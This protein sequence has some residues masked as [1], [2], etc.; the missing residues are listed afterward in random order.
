MDYQEIYKSWQNQKQ[1]DE[2]VRQDLNSIANQDD[3]IE[4]AFYTDLS[5]GTAGMRG[6]LGAG[7]NRMNR[8]TVAKATA[9]L[10]KFMNQLSSQ[11]IDRGVAI[12]YDSRYFS[13]EFALIS[14]G[15]LGAAGIKTFVFDALRPTPELSFAV[16]YLNSFAG[17]MITAS[18][19]SK[20]YNGYKIY[21]ED[22]GQLPPEHVNKVMK[23]IEDVDDIFAIPTMT[24][25]ELKE[26]GL[27]QIIGEDVDEAYLTEIKT[28]GVN[29]DLTNKIDTKI[30]YSPLHGTGKIIGM[31]ALD[32][33]GYS[34]K[35]VVE[36]AIIDG[37]FSTVEFPNPEFK[38]VFVL[39]EETAKKQG[40]EL[41]LVTDPDA[42]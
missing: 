21:G 39:P 37:G 17:I 5:F 1:L 25:M 22:G 2:F 14:A 34:A 20:E 31:R 40:A 30:V 11:E 16:R 24:E 15:V 26:K 29:K 23:Y 9:G 6:L 18:H 27:L 4:D 36:Q 19:N 7:I 28:V 3:K 8:Y 35:F 33:M 41:I 42:D 32:E 12:S 38:E 10:A 13:R